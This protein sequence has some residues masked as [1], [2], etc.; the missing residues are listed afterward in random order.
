MS[1]GCAYVVSAEVVNGGL[2]KHGVVLELR[3]AQRRGVSGDDDELGLAGAQTLEGGLV[4]ES[5]LS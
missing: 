2:G 4:T 1:D 3:L 5:N